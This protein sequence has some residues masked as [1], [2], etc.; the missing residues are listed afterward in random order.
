LAYC[1][2]QNLA[3]QAHNLDPY[4]QPATN[5]ATDPDTISIIMPCHNSAAH[6]AASV[7][8]ALE[9]TYRDIQL[10]LIDDG[11]TDNTLDVIRGIEDTRLSII[12]QDN[13]GVCAARNRGLAE[14][15]GS[16]IAFLD[17]DDNW[18][19]QC[20]EKLHAA[21]VRDKNAALAYCGWQNLGLPGGR[22]T[23]FVPPD[24]EK[25]GKI[26]SLYGNCL[27]PIHAALTKRTAIEEAGGFDARFITSEDYLLWLKIGVRHKI[28][29]VP[30]VLAY[31]HFHGIQQATGDRER[32]ARNHWLVQR[33]FLKANTWLAR[34]LGRGR[35][36][37]LTHG[38]LLKKGLVCY[39][40][41]DLDSARPIFRLVMRAGYGKLADWKLML[42]AL[43]PKSLH[44]TLVHLTD[45]TDESQ[46]AG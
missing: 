41:R 26:E 45:R 35:I 6:V 23:P 18:D 8:S 3:E 20:L 27:W 13:C 4:V 1:G 33:D 14:A 25:Q 32:L 17:S 10:I 31:Y 30:E 42:P 21:L 29:L 24:Y 44:K 38:E 11:S 19:P 7:A 37:E 22:G 12:H 34:Q 2:L 28:V 9:Q 5:M 39:W 15:K 16:F 43:L 36:R 46:G 40:G